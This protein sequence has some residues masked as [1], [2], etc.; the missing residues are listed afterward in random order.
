MDE[1]TIILNLKKSMSPFRPYTS[2]C[3]S[4]LKR[5]ATADRLGKTKH[6]EHQ[7]YAEMERKEINF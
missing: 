7:H 2:H 3:K 4:T 5:R 6:K 1:S